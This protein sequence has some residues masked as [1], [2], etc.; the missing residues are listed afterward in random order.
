MTPPIAHLRPARLADLDSIV[1]LDRST[2]FAP[3]WPVASYRT[4]LDAAGTGLDRASRCL[5]VA[6]AI[7]TGEALQPERLIGFAAG[8][9]H[10]APA[11]DDPGPRIAEL[12]DVVVAADCRRAGI[13]R[14]L[15]CAV[16]DWS[17]SQGATEVTLEVR[18]ASAGA[19]ALYIQLGF[20]R[21]G[22]RPGYYRDP[23]DDA[24]TM[25]LR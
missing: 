9:M 4:I 18:A 23:E 7:A 19:I 15:C 17:R 22:L 2:E 6:E 24:I 20:R 16:L 21:V 12:E 11:N 10:P 5:I 1:L 25:L 13:A 8:L 3:H 14:S